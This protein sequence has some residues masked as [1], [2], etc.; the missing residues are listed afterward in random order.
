MMTNSVGSMYGGMNQMQ[1]MGQGKGAGG[2]MKE[3]MQQLPQEDRQALREQMQGMDQAQRKEMMG[4]ISQLDTSNMSVEEI[5]ASILDLLDTST[6]SEEEDSS[7]D[8][9]SFSI[10]A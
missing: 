4:E 1:G 2:Q 8:S 10:Y 5:S 6:N 9:S 3:I 7:L